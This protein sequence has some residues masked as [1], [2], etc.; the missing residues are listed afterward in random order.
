MVLVIVRFV[1]Q[2][3]SAEMVVQ[4]VRVV[5]SERHQ[6]N[7][8]LQIVLR[9]ALDTSLLLKVLLIALLALQACTQI[10]LALK[11]V[12][13]A[14]PGREQQS[15]DQRSALCA[16]LDT[17]RPIRDLSDAM[18]VHLEVSLLEMVP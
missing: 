7:M 17:S 2:A 14:L 15:T 12:I 3:I 1:D 10:A 9:V 4:S 13:Y 11:D 8:A 18:N 16:A 5:L 6:P